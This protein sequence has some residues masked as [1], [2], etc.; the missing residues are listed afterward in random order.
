[1]AD[2]VAET[3][4]DPTALA[5]RLREA[6]GAVLGALRSE[7]S[8]S[9]IDLVQTERQREILDRLTGV[10]S[11]LEGHAEY[12]MDGVGPDVVPTVAEIR[13]RFQRRR[14]GRG[15][16]DQVIRRVLGLEMKMAQYRDGERFVRAVVERAGLDT[17]N[18]VWSSAE[19]LPTRAEIADPGSWITRAER[20]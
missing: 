8:V 11:L 19:M 16:L 9:I 4:L 14:A 10:M 18:R 3:E 6:V 20:G 12:V 2:F 5:S 7:R 17:F 13:Q 15:T 1:M